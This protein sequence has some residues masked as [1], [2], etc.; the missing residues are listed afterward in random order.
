M[1]ED[2]GRCRIYGE[3]LSET[4]S[5]KWNFRNPSS[6]PLLR[7]WPMR[8]FIAWPVYRVSWWYNILRV[9]PIRRTLGGRLKETRGDRLVQTAI[10]NRAAVPVPFPRILRV[11]RQGT[12][13]AR[14]AKPQISGSRWT[15]PFLASFKSDPRY[16]RLEISQRAYPTREA[17]TN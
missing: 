14:K 8:N 17:L 9:R 1:V 11:T 5:A 13:G 2:S 10:I 6:P 7:Q 12:R 16:S 4:P 3:I 15:I